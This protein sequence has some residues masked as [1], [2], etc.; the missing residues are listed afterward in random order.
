MAQ[1]IYGLV[2]HDG[3]VIGLIDAEGGVTALKGVDTERLAREA[4]PASGK[5]PSPTELAALRAAW[6]EAQGAKVQ[7]YGTGQKAPTRVQA[8]TMIGQNTT[9]ARWQQNLKWFKTDQSA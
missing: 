2:E 3:Q 5:P 1:P 9:A 4:Q 7:R 8:E 6:F